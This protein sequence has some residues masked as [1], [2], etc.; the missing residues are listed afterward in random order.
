M[1]SCIFDLWQ[2]TTQFTESECIGMTDNNPGWQTPMCLW[3]SSPHRLPMKPPSESVLGVT[4]ARANSLTNLRQLELPPRFPRCPGYQQKHVIIWC[5]PKCS[6]KHRLR[7]SL[8]AL[9]S[10]KLSKLHQPYHSDPD[11]GY[12]NNIIEYP[13]QSHWE[14][15]ASYTDGPAKIE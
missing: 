15:K 11:Q 4:V 14:L 6:L 9:A 3:K 1:Q 7:T 10:L 5:Q 2:T 8:R 12:Y 13:L